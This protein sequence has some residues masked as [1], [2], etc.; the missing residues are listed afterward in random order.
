MLQHSKEFP[1]SFGDFRHLLDHTAVCQYRLTRLQ[2]TRK[3]CLFGRGLGLSEEWKLTD[4]KGGG[5]QVQLQSLVPMGAPWI[6]T[7]LFPPLD[8]LVSAAELIGFGCSLTYDI[9]I[10]NEPCDDCGGLHGFRRILWVI[11]RLFFIVRFVVLQTPSCSAGDTAAPSLVMRVWTCHDGRRTADTSLCADRS[12]ESVTVGWLCPSPSWLCFP[13]PPHLWVAWRF[14]R[15]AV[16]A[17][18]SHHITV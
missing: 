4:V 16:V 2:H 15:V 8:Q 1:S 17:A 3:F 6:T 5:S 10:L 7:I 12:T 9:L 18:T 11:I 13:D 14:V